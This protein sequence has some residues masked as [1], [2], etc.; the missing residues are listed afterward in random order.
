MKI[1]ANTV[2]P[3]TVSK[4][5]WH[6]TGGPRWN[7][8]KKT[9][10][11]HPKPANKAFDALCGIVT[12]KQ[13]RL[14]RYREL[15]K[16]KVAKRVRDPRTNKWMK[17]PEEIVERESA[18]VCCLAD[19]PVAHLSYHAG[20]Y[21]KIAIGFHR[22]APLHA[23]FNPVFYTPHNSTVMKMIH[24]SIEALEKVSEEQLESVADDVIW[25]ELD[26]LK[27]EKNHPVELPSGLS[28]DMARSFSKAMEPIGLANERL[29][30]FLAF[31]KTFD[32]GEFSTIY[33]EREWRSTA[34][35]SFGLE[36]IAMIVLPKTGEAQLFRRFIDEVATAIDLPRSV[37]LVPWEDLI[38]H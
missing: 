32:E 16:V 25:S 31:I 17:G 18:P 19:I 30:N 11:S 13:L 29:K 36:N 12:S 35:F 20:R 15:V 37:P 5:L 4:I 24:R 21:G 3:G 1:S 38:E 2:P 6:F 26:D 9:Q 10:Y 27:C 28:W 22:D 34:D 14:G 33:C 8:A 23:G 7:A